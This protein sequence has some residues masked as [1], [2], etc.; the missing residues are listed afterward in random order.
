MSLDWG[1]HPAWKASRA[2]WDTGCHASWATFGSV[3]SQR[4]RNEWRRP[5][6]CCSSHHCT[7]LTSM[8][9]RMRERDV[10][11]RVRKKSRIQPE[12][13]WRRKKSDKCGRDVQRGWPRMNTYSVFWRAADHTARKPCSPELVCV[14]VSV[15]L[16]VC[17]CICVLLTCIQL[18]ATPWTVACQ[19]PLSTGFS[20]QEYFSV[21]TGVGSHSLLQGTF[22]TPGI[23]HRS[24]ALQAD[25][26]P[27][28]PPGK[29]S[30]A[31]ILHNFH[32]GGS[33]D[34]ETRAP[35]SSCSQAT[36]SSR[37]TVTMFLPLHHLLVPWGTH[38]S[39]AP[40]GALR[41]S[42][43]VGR[44]RLGLI[45]DSFSTQHLS[46]M[47][48]ARPTEVLPKQTTKYMNSNTPNFSFSRGF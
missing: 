28:E 11:L 3:S 41:L 33:D 45:S 30:G 21:Y 9:G 25:P 18:F 42:H 44:L 20:R 22:P 35:Q 39:L 31:H 7:F 43:L 6:I 24:P 38:P 13:K 23:E 1:L 16:S 46:E 26:L 17:L 12:G 14:C 27:S 8:W 37:T 5:G 48:Q 47:T 32:Q 34:P 4:W 10:S 40:W 2:V 19:T 29:P 36:G 15:C